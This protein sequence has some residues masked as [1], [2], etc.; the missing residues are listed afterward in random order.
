[1]ATGQK[2]L[3]SGFGIEKFN[4]AWWMSSINPRTEKLAY[5][6]GGPRIPCHMPPRSRLHLT[7]AF[8]QIARI[9]AAATSQRQI[10]KRAHSSS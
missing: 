4:A 2:F 5:L 7:R 3:H 8:D 1:L 6:S 9:T 10:V